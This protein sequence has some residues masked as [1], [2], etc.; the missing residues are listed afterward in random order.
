M[1]AKHPKLRIPTVLAW[2]AFH[3]VGLGSAGCVDHGSTRGAAICTE[4]AG[5]DAGPE[6]G[7][8]GQDACGPSVPEEPA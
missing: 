6:A 3:G 8:A 4:D 7:D 5:V 1:N 2:T